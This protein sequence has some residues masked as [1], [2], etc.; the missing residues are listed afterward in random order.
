MLNTK[1]VFAKNK[2]SCSP[3]KKLLDLKQCRNYHYLWRADELCINNRKKDAFSFWK[4]V[5]PFKPGFGEW[6]RYLAVFKN[7]INVF[8]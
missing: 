6:N 5:N 7:I 8:K 2:L 3:E 1:E 4:R